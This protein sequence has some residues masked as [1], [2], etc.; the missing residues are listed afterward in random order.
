MQKQIAKAYRTASIWRCGS[1]GQESRWC[2]ASDKPCW[3]ERPLGE[4]I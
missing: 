1:V 2:I 4:R 3:T